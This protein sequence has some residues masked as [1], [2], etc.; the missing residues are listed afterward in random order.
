M[1]LLRRVMPVLG[2]HREKRN[3][4]REIIN[5]AS[6]YLLSVIV[7]LDGM[8]ASA[9]NGSHIAFHAEC[10]SMID[11]FYRVHPR[12]GV[13]TPAHP[14]IAKNM[15]RITAGSGGCLSISHHVESS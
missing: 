6:T 1:L 3:S 9:G 14:A 8:P 2:L 15:I 10:R 4:D 7:P 12:M 5:G 11:R 13:V